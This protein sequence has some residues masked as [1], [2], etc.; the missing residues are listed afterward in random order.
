MIPHLFY[1]QLMSLGLL[2]LCVML[3]LAWPS[4]AAVSPQR[5]GKPESPITPPRKSSNEPKAF[6]GLTHKPFCALREQETSPSKPPPSVQPDPMPPTHRR[7]R[8]IDTSRHFCPHLGCAYRGWLGLGNLRANGLPVAAV[9]AGD[10]GWIDQSRVVASR[11]PPL[12]GATV[13][14]ASCGVRDRQG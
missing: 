12:S 5:P 4:R 8:A 3:H 1:Y 7:P 9:Y 14:A 10:G 13:A 11:S 6:A 2:W